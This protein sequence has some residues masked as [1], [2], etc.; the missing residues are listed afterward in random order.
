MNF[1][2]LGPMFNALTTLASL[3]AIGLSFYVRATVAQKIDSALAAVYT[4]INA[5][6]DRLSHLEGVV[7]DIPRAKDIH[8]MALALSDMAGD[9]KAIKA[10]MSAIELSS[11]ANALAL[12]RVE[13]HLFAIKD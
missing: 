12:R 2:A 13:N 6:H 1:E 8:T 9:L 4:R 10:Q 7:D 11:G 5:D 3:A